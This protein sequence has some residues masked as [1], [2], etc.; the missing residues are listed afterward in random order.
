[1]AKNFSQALES[2]NAIGRIAERENH[3][4]DV[5]LT[6]YRNVEIVLYTHSIGGVSAND[7][8]LARMIEEEVGCKREFYSPKWSR[9][10]G[11][12]EGGTGSC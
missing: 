9:E 8:S 2:I 11:V 3:H 5:H 4:P 12:G 1:M 10:N 7:L 6:G